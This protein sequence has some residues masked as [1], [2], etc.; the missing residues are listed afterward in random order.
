MNDLQFDSLKVFKCQNCH[1]PLQVDPTML[2]LSKSQRELLLPREDRRPGVEEFNLR[3]ESQDMLKKVKTGKEAKQLLKEDFQ[4]S[5]FLFLRDIDDS[6]AEKDL[7]KGLEGD[8]D[9]RKSNED[10]MVSELDVE[11]TAKTLS[12]QIERL[13]KLFEIMSTSESNIDY[14][15]CQECCNIMMKRLKTD[16]EKAVKERDL[17]FQF[18]KRIEKQQLDESDSSQLSLRQ[19]EYTDQTKK[20]NQERERLLLELTKKEQVEEELDAEI[21]ELTRQISEK[22]ANERATR[23]IDNAK[24]WDKMKL[25]NDISSLQYQYE[26]ELNKLDQLRKTNIY[27]ES[28]RISHQGPFATISGLKL[29]SYEDHK[30]SYSEI[31]A[32]L[33]Q[34]VLLLMTISSSLNIKISGY[35][36]QPIGST[37]KVS[38]FLADKEDW[39]TYE[40]Y[41][42][43]NFSLEKIFKRETD[44]DKGMESLLDIVKQISLSFSTVVSSDTDINIQDERTR[45]NDSMLNG[46]ANRNANLRA[47]RLFTESELPYMIDGDRI[48]GISVKLYGAE[49]NLEWTTA[50]KFLLTDAK[51][52]LV[53]CSSKLSL[54]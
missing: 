47:D 20:I 10:S 16:Y 39:E 13:S 9:D 18:V 51:W 29:G 24:Q 54:Q 15:I 22:K 44:F 42:S 19:K 46:G 17:Y 7:K 8:N 11:D 40:L 52:L 45:S 33:G 28:F 36:L 3:Q 27:N 38:K 4:S 48:N 23:K 53:F 12:T 26:T 5:D 35:R 21:A 41:F 25:L 32:A 6:I 49:P 50:M 34:L 1:L 30:V 37:S 31:N 43:S 14:P 2:H